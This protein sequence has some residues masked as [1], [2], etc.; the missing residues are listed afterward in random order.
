MVCPTRGARATAAFGSYWD[1]QIQAGTG[2]LPEARE[3]WLILKFESPGK[4]ALKI[5]A[6]LI[7]EVQSARKARGA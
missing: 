4:R 6:V 7:R 5:D 2:E 1:G 3:R